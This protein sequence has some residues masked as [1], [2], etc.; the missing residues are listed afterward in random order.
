MPTPGRATVSV[1]T[2]DQTFQATRLTSF[3]PDSASDE[4]GGNATSAY[5]LDEIFAA[6]SD[7]HCAVNA[8]Q[9]L[10]FNEDV[11]TSTYA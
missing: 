4:S 1:E 5:T 3:V 6:S 8:H 2:R 7:E 9:A 10:L 11:G